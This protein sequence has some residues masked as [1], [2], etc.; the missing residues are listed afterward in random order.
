M[1]KTAERYAMSEAPSV[2]FY[3]FLKS[4]SNSGYIIHTQIIFKK[5]TVKNGKQENG[6]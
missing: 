6:K 4:I 3:V 1:T 5:E 2:V